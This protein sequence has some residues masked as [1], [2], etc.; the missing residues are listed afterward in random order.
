MPESD[1]DP[2]ALLVRGLALGVCGTDKEIDGYGSELWRVEPEY[3]VV[4]DTGLERVGMLMEP[5]TVVAKAWEQIE[6]VGAR[7]WFE[8]R[9]VLVTGAGPIGLLAVRRGLDVHVLDRV[10]G[11]PKPTLV[12]SVNANLRP[13]RQAADALAKAD[14]TWLDRLVTRRV[15]LTKATDTFTAGDGDVEVVITLSE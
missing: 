1:P 5:T 15:P 12:G 8:P 3:T 14:L 10:T 13:Y 11:R 6:R 2:G 4:P 9:T 7:S